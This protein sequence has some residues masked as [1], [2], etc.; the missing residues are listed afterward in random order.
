MWFSLPRQGLARRLRPLTASLV[1]PCVWIV[2][3]LA[4]MLPASASATPQRS[5][6]SAPL[7]DPREL[8]TFLQGVVARQMATYHIPGVAAVVVKDGHILLSKGYGYADLQRGQQVQPDHTVFRLGS[9]SKLC[10]WTALMQLVEEGKVNLHADVNT[11]LKTFHIPP[12]YPQPITIANL[13]THTAGFE[14]GTIGQLV[15]APS[16][17]E[18]LGTWL[19]RHLPARIFPPDV[20]TAYSDYG[21]ALAGYIVEQVA[22][23]PFEQYIQQHLFQPLNMQQSTFRQPLPATLS[24]QMSQGYSYSSGTYHP[25][26]FENIET[27]PAGA[28]SS[29]A[30][31]MAHFMLAQLQAGHFGRTSILQDTTMQQMQQQH[32][33]N[34]PRLPGMTYGFYEQNIDQQRLLVHS[35]DTTLFS[36]LVVLL[37][38]SHVGLFFAFNSLGG[39]NA[40]QNLLQAFMD[41]YYPAPPIAPVALLPGFSERTHQIEGT[42]WSTRR[43]ETTYQKVGYDLLSPVTVH[44]S[45]GGRV[46]VTGV[47]SQDINLLEVQPWIFQ[48]INGHSNTVI[49]RSSGTQ[50]TMFIGNRPYQAYQKRAWDETPMFHLGLLL[51]C[52]LIFLGAVLQACAH[53]VRTIRGKR[54][55]DQRAGTWHIKLVHWLGWV[56]SAFNV[57]VLIGLLLLFSSDDLYAVQ[58]A[59][60]SALV[61]VMVLAS[62][63]ALLTLGMVSCHFLAWRMLSRRRW[64]YLFSVVLTLA[65]IAFSVDLHFWHLL[66]L[67]W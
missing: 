12:T 17:L 57:I 2:F 26:S 58:F 55:R 64:R 59:M 56:M 15:R 45:D 31:D 34:D 14:D 47:G 40:S 39:D 30:T 27:V 3:A 24:G 43:N 13:L 21:A 53:F 36:S 63:S 44:A 11:Y 19:P 52:L 48:Q 61:A 18:P 1:F 54:D 9:V 22:G 20:V 6:S 49:F 28:L 60:S 42:Y 38:K 35:G 25:G 33:T 10:T 37:P 4:L 29:T 62:L 41:H 23:M 7:G 8:E 51:L 16:D 50:M 46:V 5:V 65:G 32:F 67:P 66:W